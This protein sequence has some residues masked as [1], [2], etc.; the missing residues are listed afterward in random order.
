VRPSVADAASWG[1]VALVLLLTPTALGAQTVVGRV[2]DEVR[3]SPVGGALVRLLDKDGDERAQALA[4][5]VGRFVL[6]PPRAGEYYLEASR[7]GYRRSLTPLLAFSGADG[8]IPLDLMMAP[9]PI[10]L[11]G[12]AVEVD[13]ETRATEEMKAGGIRPRDLG[14]RWI[15]RKAIEAVPITRD[16]GSVLERNSIANIRIIRPENLVPGSDAL[17]LCVALA[18]A[19]TASGSGTCALIVLNGVPITGEQALALDPESVEAMAVLLPREAATLFGSRGGRGAL[20][21]WTR[22]GGGS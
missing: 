20:L 13:V 6:A 8:S 21:I 1:A 19:R 9:A 18:R 12:L 4:D 5:E 2:L 7:I 15:D 16:V 14:N 17:G 3:G 22:T 11:E 10:G